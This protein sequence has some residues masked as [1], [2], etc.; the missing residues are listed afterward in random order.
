MINTL[1]QTEWITEYADKTGSECIKHLME[2]YVNLEDEAVPKIM[3]K[4]YNEPWMN[5][6]I[7][8]LWKKKDCSWS[9]L[10]EL[11]SKNRWKRYRRDRDKLSLNKRKAKR[12]HEGKIAK[13]ARVN[14]KAFF[15]YVNSR[16][17][18]RP[19]I[20]ALKKSDDTIVEEDKDIVEVQVDYFSTV[21]TAHRG[22]RMPEM[23]EMTDAEITDI[24]ITP[25]MVETKLR[26]LNENKSSG[27]DVFH[28]YVLKKAAHELSVPLA[29][30]YQKVLD[31]GVC[32]TEWKCANVT[33]IHKKGDRTDP[34]NYRPVKD[35]GRFDREIAQFK[36]CLPKSIILILC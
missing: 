27:S 7:M 9:R 25:E 34:S 5:P 29:I 28:P 35:H 15:K 21:Y 3:P 17:T 16:L 2:K 1:S 36:K 14:K 18:V 12:I 33:P 24:N 19:E 32:P 20:I 13:N 6:K 22:E 11:N 30:I 31:E 4:D 23:Q 26:K 8:K 10:Q